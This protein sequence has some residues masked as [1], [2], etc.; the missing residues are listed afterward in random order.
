MQ[1]LQEAFIEHEHDTAQ[2]NKS[3]VALKSPTSWIMTVGEHAMI[4]VPNATENHGPNHTIVRQ[5]SQVCCRAG[6]IQGIT[7]I[8]TG[9]ATDK[10]TIAQELTDKIMYKGLARPEDEVTDHAQMVWNQYV[11]NVDARVSTLGAWSAKI[12]HLILHSSRKRYC[13]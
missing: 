12:L 9:H 13:T 2:G 8:L 4:R 10:A 3:V 5:G 7:E 11:L 1:E 6:G